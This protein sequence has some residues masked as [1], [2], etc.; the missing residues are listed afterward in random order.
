MEAGAGVPGPRPARSGGRRSRAAPLDPADR[1]RNRAARHR[2]RRP[3]PGGESRRPPHDHAAPRGAQRHLP[4]GGLPAGRPPWGSPCRH[5]RLGRAPAQ[6]RA[7]PGADLRRHRLPAEGRRRP[8]LQRPAPV[9]LR[10]GLRPG[11]RAQARPGHPCGGL[12]VPRDPLPGRRRPLRRQPVRR[13]LE[14]L[15]RGVLRACRT[16][17][18]PGALGVRPRQSRELRARRPR[19][20]PPAGP[21]A[22][23]ARLPGAERA[24]PCEDG[25]HQPL[26]AGQRGQLRHLRA[27]RPGEGLR[28]PAGRLRPRA[29]PWPGLDRHPPASLGPD[30]GGA[31]GPAGAGRGRVEPHRAGGGARPP[32]ARRA[33]DR[34]GPHPSLRRL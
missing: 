2:A 27:R 26:C 12:L 34:L 20:V 1:P 15:G 30:P 33:D 6:G 7:A 31:T 16:P 3:V 19:M 9:A 18:R 23:A 32:H 10:P 24:V 25:R 8:G 14:R 4:G 5:R 17:A 29:R 21:G 22:R 28:R 11:G 13:Q